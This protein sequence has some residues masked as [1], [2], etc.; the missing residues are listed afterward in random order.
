M[1]SRIA[2]EPQV[3]EFSVYDLE[4]IPGTCEVRLCGVYDG[5]DYRSYTSVREFLRGELVA[6]TSG[7]W[8]YAHAGG[9]ADMTFLIG[10]FAGSHAPFAGYHVEASFS[11]SSAVIVTIRKGRLK[12]IFV[13]SYWLLRGKLADIAKSLGLKKTAD[14]NICSNFPSCGHLSREG[15]LAQELGEEVERRDAHCVFH[16]P[17]PILRDYNEQDCRI[18][19][20]AIDAF[21]ETIVQLG[22]QLQMTIASCAMRLFRMKYLDQ[23]VETHEEINRRA[24]KAYTASRVEIFQESC[25]Y[26]FYYD[27][28]SSFS[29]AMI[30]AGPGAVSRISTRLPAAQSAIFLADVEIEVPPMYLPPI[31][32]RH[33]GR[34]FFPTGRWRAWIASVDLDLL[35]RRGGR[36]H[37]VHEVVEF[38]PLHAL[39]GYAEDLYA[40]RAAE[41]DPFVKIVFKFLLNALYGKFA[42]GTEKSYLALNPPTVDCMHSPRHRCPMWPHCP[43]GRAGIE[44]STCTKVLFPGALMVTHEIDIEHEHVPLST[45]ITAV[46]RANLEQHLHA[47]QADLHYCDTDSAITT[48]VLPTSKALGAL[49]LERLVIDGVFVKPKLY[50]THAAEIDALVEKDGTPKPGVLGPDGRFDP[51]APAVERFATQYIKAKGFSRVDLRKFEALRRGDEISIDRMA[52]VREIV[53]AQSGGFNLQARETVI[54]KRLKLQGALMDKR[55][56][57]PTGQSRPWSIDEIQTNYMAWETPRVEVA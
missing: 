19:W 55:C 4:W 11:G 8:Y 51:R 54:K 57:L 31:P 14:D 27:L 26:G 6:A 22:G 15:R 42:E 29:A 52:R 37:R 3:R 20:Q 9:L 46:A 56:M 43:H 24:R 16:A 40:R 39:R 36:L 41:T 25:G 45:L 30:P 34:I 38:H 50:R 2:D 33:K 13:D 32:Y 12:W 44:C 21:Q 49:K 53:T 48:V 1:L 18:L 17:L 10:A 23:D 5:D 7:R 28:N 47:A 35:L